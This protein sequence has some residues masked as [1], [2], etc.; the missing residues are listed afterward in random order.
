MHDMIDSAGMLRGWIDIWTGHFLWLLATLTMS[1]GAVALV[2]QLF[3]LRSSRRRSQI[4]S[5]A[6]ARHSQS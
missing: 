2:E 4:R 3:D 5:L 1:V 6:P